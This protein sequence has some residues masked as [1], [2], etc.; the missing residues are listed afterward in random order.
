MGVDVLSVSSKGQIV[1]PVEMRRELE[2][3]AGAK[4]AA[5]VLGDII[6]LKPINVPTED[7]FRKSLD[8]ASDWAKKVG[9]KEEDV[10]DIIKSF[11]KNKK[12]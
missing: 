2:I 8:E 10:N 6:M 12:T 5:Y 3:G 4:L 11:R 1:L 7:D 9:Y